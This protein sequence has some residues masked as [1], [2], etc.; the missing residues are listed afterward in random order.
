MTLFR[1]LV[2]TAVCALATGCLSSR[3]QTAQNDNDR[4]AARGLQPNTD[5]FSDCLLGL[6]TER[7]VRKESRRRDMMERS[8]MPAAATR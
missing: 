2:L 4:C 6:Q 1:A 8:N 3:E 7:D 5:R